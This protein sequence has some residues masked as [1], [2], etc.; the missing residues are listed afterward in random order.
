MNARGRLDVR[1]S[2]RVGLDTRL[3]GDEIGIPSR[4]LSGLSSVNEFGRTPLTRGN[5]KLLSGPASP[6]RTSYEDRR[7]ILIAALL[8]LPVDGV[9]E[10]ERPDE[11]EGSSSSSGDIGGEFMMPG[12]KGRGPRSSEFSSW[13]N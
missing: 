6:E 8:V 1:L 2:V 12:G 10:C 9:Y 5:G 4:M 3:L 7:C 11:G 13:C